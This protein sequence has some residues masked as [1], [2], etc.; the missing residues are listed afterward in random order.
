MHWLHFHIFSYPSFYFYLFIS[1]VCIGLACVDFFHFLNSI[2]FFSFF[3]IGI[4]FQAR[5]TLDI[6]YIK[7][8]LVLYRRRAAKKGVV[9]G[10]SYLG[11][12]VS[13]DFVPY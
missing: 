13:T 9:G 7:P 4:C 6:K 3:S 2:T 10:F 8:H 11:P 1:F 12:V 5:V